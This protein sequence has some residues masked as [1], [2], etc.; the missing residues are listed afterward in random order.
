MGDK[1][2]SKQKSKKETKKKAKN[3]LLEK[4]KIKKEKKTNK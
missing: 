2:T 3:T 1:G 4:R